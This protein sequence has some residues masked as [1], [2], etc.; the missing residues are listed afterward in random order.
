MKYLLDIL[1]DTYNELNDEG[2]IAIMEKYW[3][4][5][6]RNAEI[7]ICKET[8]FNAFTQEAI[9]T[10]YLFQNQYSV[11]CNYLL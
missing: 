11:K 1:Q 6:K 9:N 2:E 4:I 7:F 3:A 8:C 5:A 10:F